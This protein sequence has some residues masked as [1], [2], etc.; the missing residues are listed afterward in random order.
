LYNGLGF[1]INSNDQ[2]FTMSINMKLKDYVK[3]IQIFQLKWKN[4]LILFKN[5]KKQD[6]F[7]NDNDNKNNYSDSNLMN[8]ENSIDN[9]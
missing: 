2:E 6:F 5:N 7:R 9:Y 3:L 8:D 4:D 1:L